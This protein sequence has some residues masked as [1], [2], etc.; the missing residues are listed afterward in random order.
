M[1]TSPGW[2]GAHGGVETTWRRAT[3]VTEATVGTFMDFPTAREFAFAA[4]REVR[5]GECVVARDA[6]ANVIVGRVEKLTA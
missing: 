5:L 2:G 1:R 3:R 6:A 4:I